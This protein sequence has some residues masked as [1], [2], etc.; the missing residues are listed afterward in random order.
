MRTRKPGRSVHTKKARMVEN[1]AKTVLWLA[2]GVTIF[3]LLWIIGYI[4]YNGFVTDVKKIYP[5]ISEGTEVVMLDSNREHDVVFIVNS[6]VRLESL[7]ADEIAG[8]FT[9][10]QKDWTVSGQDLKV[11]TFSLGTSLPPGAAF[12]DAVIGKDGRFAAGNRVLDSAD[13]MLRNVA[14]TV[15]A[16]GFVGEKNREQAEKAPGVKVIRV[17]W[18]ALA[19][20][21]GVFEIRTQKK[22]RFLTADAVAGIFS[23]RIRNWEQAGGITLGL[24]PVILDPRLP[25]ARI[26]RD[27]VLGKTEGLAPNARIVNSEDE[28]LNEIA[29]TPGAVGFGNYFFLKS[30]VPGLII[31]VQRE[32][33]RQNLDF[34]YLIE[35]PKKF[36]KVGGVSTIIVNTLMMILL[37]V[38][39]AT[40]IGVGAAV[41]LTEYARAGRL[42]SVLRFFTETLAGIPSIIFGLFGYL[43]FVN[44]LGFKEGLLS[45]TLTITLM[46]LPTIIRTAEEALKAVPGSYREE[47]FALGATMWQTVRGVVIPAALPGILTGVILAVGRAVGETA[48]VIFTMGNSPY[49]AQSL[50][51]SA[52]VLSVHLYLLAKE[53]VS[54]E[55]AYATGTILIVI[56]LIVNIIAVSLIGKMNRMYKP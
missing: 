42:V 33:I 5:V 34:A 19:A 49:M 32:E 29:R 9:G 8:F 12:K 23:G 54:F 3:V 37:T 11:K 7:A 6:G 16:I 17:R 40:P 50:F 36:G 2:S 51:S 44:F 24:T 25:A 55:R 45:G 30:R 18:L 41:Y 14:D 35:E 10:E 13:G 46:V 27:L 52:R 21:P 53:G 22:L 56:I 38:L 15:G 39:L 31:P 28:L 43:V 4:V 47:S 48:A 20:N 1:T 26:F